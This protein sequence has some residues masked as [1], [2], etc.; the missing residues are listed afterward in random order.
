MQ[1]AS[2]SQVE[3]EEAEEENLYD[4]LNMADDADIDAIVDALLNDD[5]VEEAELPYLA[6]RRPVVF[7]MS[8][9]TGDDRA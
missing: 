9:E 6:A 7:A 5:E 1:H 4:L 8:V 2:S 3:G